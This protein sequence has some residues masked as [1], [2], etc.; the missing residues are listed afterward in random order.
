VLLEDFITGDARS[1]YVVA[2]AL[3]A[4]ALI[5]WVVDHRATHT[6]ALASLT[7]RDA[8]FIGLAQACALIPGVSRSGATIACALALG[9]ARPDA[10]RFSFLLGIPAIAAAGIFELKDALAA[11]LGGAAP[12]LVGAAAAFVSGYASIAWLLRFLA[13]RTMTPFVVYRIALAVLLVA[14]CVG[15]A[16][17]PL[18]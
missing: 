7:W 16:V 9:F 3:A 15:G 12:L 5:I 8:L 11:P 10:A 6:R 17:S 2:G 13:R 1:L 4:V 14:L 18:D